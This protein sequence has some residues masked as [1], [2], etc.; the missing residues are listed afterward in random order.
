MGLALQSHHWLQFHYPGWV[1][2]GVLSALPPT[3]L[4]ADV[5]GNGAAGGSLGPCTREGEQ[6]KAVG[7]QLW[8]DSVW[9]LQLLGSEQLV[10][11]R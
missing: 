7:C 2:V 1:P 3:Q 11:E 5:P 6:V 10:E 4:S 9:P 8:I